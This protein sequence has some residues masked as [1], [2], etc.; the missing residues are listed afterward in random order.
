MEEIKRLWRVFLGKKAVEKGMCNFSVLLNLSLDR[1][2]RQV[3][4]RS[5]VKDYYRGVKVEMGEKLNKYQ[6]HMT[7]CC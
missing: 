4:E 2:V 6:I 7:Q 1:V 3:N 5:E